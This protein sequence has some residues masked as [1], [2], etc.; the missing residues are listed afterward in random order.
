MTTSHSEIGFYVH[1]RCFVIVR[2]VCVCV[3]ISLFLCVRKSEREKSWCQSLW[4]YFFP[5]TERTNEVLEFQRLLPFLG[6]ARIHGTFSRNCTAEFIWNKWNKGNFFL[7]FYLVLSFSL[8][9]VAVFFPFSFVF[10]QRTFLLL[11][12]IWLYISVVSVDF[13]SLSV[14]IHIC[15]IPRYFF[16]FSFH[17]LISCSKTILTYS[18]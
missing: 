7:F 1:F 3:W 8:S 13:L 4:A 17:S 12:G 5:F 10:L 18:T 14:S 16:H 2:C 15:G 9:N 11:S 6:L